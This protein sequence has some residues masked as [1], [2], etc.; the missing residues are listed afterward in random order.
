[1]NDLHSS[2]PRE[3]R[4]RWR[5]ILISWGRTCRV[6]ILSAILSSAH[7]TALAQVLGGGGSDGGRTTRDEGKEP[8]SA[9]GAGS[10]PSE[11]AEAAPHSPTYELPWGGVYLRHQG[12]CCGGNLQEPSGLTV[13]GNFKT[14]GN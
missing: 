8:I 13:V 3:S 9:E 12:R 4:R 1:M 10:S 7:Q 2:V 5:K 11:I 6:K 14:P